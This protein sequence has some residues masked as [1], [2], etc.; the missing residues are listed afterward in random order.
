MLIYAYIQMLMD[1][2]GEN[3]NGECSFDE[4]LKIEKGRLDT[5]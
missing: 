5:Q 4:L 2:Y 3:P 1:N